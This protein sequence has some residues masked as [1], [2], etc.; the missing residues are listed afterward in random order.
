VAVATAA[1]AATDS[2]RQFR[3]V[4]V[5]D[6][7]RARELRKRL[8]PLRAGELLGKSGEARTGDWI[9]VTSRGQD[10]GQSV[11]AVGKALIDFEQLRG[12]DADALVVDVVELMWPV[13]R[14]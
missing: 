13:P 11:F 2:S 12:V 3:G 1:V 10:G 9:Y 4:V 14:S 5:V 7:R 6:G 8:A